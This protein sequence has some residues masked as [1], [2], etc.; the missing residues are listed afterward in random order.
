MYPTVCHE[1]SQASWPIGG[2]C[3]AFPRRGSPPSTRGGCFYFQEAQYEV[4]T[5]AHA[6]TAA[7]ITL[8]T[9]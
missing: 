1:Y 6:M 3:G 7:P 5:T 9:R 8:A 4:Y 2:I